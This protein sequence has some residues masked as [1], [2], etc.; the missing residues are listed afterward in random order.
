[1]VF[2]SVRRHSRPGADVDRKTT[3]DFGRQLREWR[4]HRNLSQL[5]LA[6]EAGI[7]PRHLSFLE[8]GRSRPTEGMII[9]I[10]E[11]LDLPFRAQ[12]ELFSAAGFTPRFASVEREGI[13]GLPKPVRE[14][15]A[16]ILERHAPWPAVVF[17]ADHDILTVN[18]GFAALGSALGISAGPGANL[19]G[20]V[21]EPGPV[22]EAIV[23]FDAVAG[24]FLRRA[25][26]EARLYGPRSALAKR[27][28]RYEADAGLGRLFGAGAAGRNPP[29]VIAVRLRLGDLETQWITTLTS[30]GSAQE[31]LSEGIFIE[32]YFPA[33]ERTK[34]VAENLASR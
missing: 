29:P 25:R 22:R 7:S 6:M 28:S 18:A 31:V 2:L 27:L 4:S 17:N 20:L 19:L 8:T 34:V 13:E 21:V 16:L 5:D 32:Q 26:N 14:A 23:N 30:F 3:M 10:A 33:D 12:N 24:L 15:L 11:A 1:M 9:R